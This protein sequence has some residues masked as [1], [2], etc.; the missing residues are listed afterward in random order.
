[1][2]HINEL[3]KDISRNQYEVIEMPEPLRFNYTS[4]A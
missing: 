3:L 2:K 1:M 4:I